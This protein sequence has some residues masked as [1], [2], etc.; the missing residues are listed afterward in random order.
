M[1][2][3]KTSK[4]KK[5]Q[6]KTKKKNKNNSVKKNHITSNSQANQSSHPGLCT[7]IIISQPE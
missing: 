6:N 1:T 5:K 3:K 4:T 7:L 2:S